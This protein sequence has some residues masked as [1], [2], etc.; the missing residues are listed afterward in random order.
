MWKN[1]GEVQNA[2]EEEALKSCVKTKHP[3]GAV[4]ICRGDR[5]HPNQP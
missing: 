2:W 4:E 5:E 3:I 1:Q